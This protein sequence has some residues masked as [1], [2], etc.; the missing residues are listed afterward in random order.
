VR[1]QGTDSI[2]WEEGTRAAP[3]GVQKP[4]P[5]AGMAELEEEVRWAS[6][7]VGR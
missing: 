2:A 4:D 3:S 7:G 5:S 6:R 1:G